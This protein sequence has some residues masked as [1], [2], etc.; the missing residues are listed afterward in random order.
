V[1]IVGAGRA[2]A[3]FAAALD[4]AG[5]RVVAATTASHSFP[6]LEA[7]EG[8]PRLAAADVAAMSELLVLTVPDDTLPGLVHGLAV[9]GALRPGQI[10]VHAAGRYGLEVLAPATE[11]GALP[12][13]LHPAMTF[14]GTEADLARLADAVI[15]VTAP[16]EFRVVGEALAIEL[17][18]EPVF[19][20][21]EL[22]VRWH[23][24]L[25]HGANHLVTLVGQCVDLLVSAGVEHPEHVLR[26]LLSAALENAL[27]EGDA[28]LTGPVVRGDVG[29]VAAHLRELAGS[30]ALESYLA[31]A[32]AT[33]TRATKAGRLP[34]VAA[35]AVREVLDGPR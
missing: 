34:S 33:L 27:R 16:P 5:H 3:A 8:L 29:T 11:A 10:V 2:G 4:R 14:S 26:P 20:P 18:G 32:G 31:L 12:I 35:T 15:A 22:R 17:G 24:A 13:A 19:I 23:T 1:G 28:A 7:F 30:S 6:L 21:D 9:T 25:A